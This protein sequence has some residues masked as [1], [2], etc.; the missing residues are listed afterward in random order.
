MISPAYVYIYGSHKMKYRPFAQEFICL[1]HDRK[2]LKKID[3][4]VLIGCLR[5]SR[6]ISSVEQHWN[7]I[8]KFRV[9]FMFSL[10][11]CSFH[12]SLTNQMNPL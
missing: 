4:C 8:L 5:V 6:E 12:W 11:P 3:S 7:D 10:F 1:G 2:F 9:W